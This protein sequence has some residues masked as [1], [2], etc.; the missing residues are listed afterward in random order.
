MPPRLHVAG[1]ELALAHEIWAEPGAKDQ[2]QLVAW[3][4]THC[5]EWTPVTHRRAPIAIERIA[6]ALGKAPAVVERLRREAAELNLLGEIF[7]QA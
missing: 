1:A 4:H 5:S 7:A 2:W 3:C 6:L